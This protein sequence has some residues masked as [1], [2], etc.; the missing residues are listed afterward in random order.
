VSPW[1][2]AAAL[3]GAAGVALGAFGAHALKSRLA[4]DLLAAWQTAVEYH[5]FHSVAL[6]ALGLFASATGRSVR[7]PAFLLGGGIVLF[8]GSL[9]LL[10][11]AGLRW[12]GPLTPLG[13]LL[14]IAGW[15]SLLTLA[16]D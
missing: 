6:L 7:L 9:Y 13:G 12:A 3:F 5:L 2:A 16:R 1:V 15:L 4:P 10:A 11:G 8:S 14:L